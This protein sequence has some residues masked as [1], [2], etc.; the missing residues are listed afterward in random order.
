MQYA[1]ITVRVDVHV[2]KTRKEKLATPINHLDF[3]RWQAFL[4]LAGSDGG[5]SVTLD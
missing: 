4:I 1:V 3:L 2:P 5:N